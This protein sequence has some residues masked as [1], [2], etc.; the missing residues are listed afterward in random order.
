MTSS[1]SL[2]ADGPR[3]PETVDRLM[4]GVCGAIW[5]VWL[6]VAVIAT[7]ALVNLG[8]GRD[9]APRDSSWLL[10]TVIAVSAVTIAAAIPL[11]LRARRDAMAERGPAGPAP[12]AEQVARQA[13]EAPTEKIRIFGTAIDPSGPEPQPPAAQGVS[14]QTGELD[15]HWLRATLSILGAIGLGWT[16]V[17]VAT[18]LLAVDSGTAATVALG[19]A[20]AFTAAIPAVVVAFSRRLNATL[21]RA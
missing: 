16:A 20:A 7:V 6:V 10:Y 2:P 9:G 3:P 5:L 12:A 21:G 19:I 14:G 18:Y 13:A 15:R 17:A 4:A 8:R 11:L 1:S